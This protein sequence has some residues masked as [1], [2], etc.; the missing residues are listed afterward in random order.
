MTYT[1]EITKDGKTR[2]FGFT[3]ADK[4]S[5]FAA[6]MTREGFMTATS[7]RDTLEVLRAM[8]PE[9]FAVVVS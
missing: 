3:S 9:K 8:F 4:A 7:T 2:S 6:K 5:R 1:V